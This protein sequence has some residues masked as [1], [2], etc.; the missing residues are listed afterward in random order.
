MIK[1]LSGVLFSFLAMTL[2]LAENPPGVESFTDTVVPTETVETPD[3]LEELLLPGGGVYLGEIFEHMPHGKGTISYPNGEQY[4]GHF[5]D[6]KKT[7]EGTLRLVSGDQLSAFWVDDRRMGDVSYRFVD[8]RVYQ[9]ELKAKKA[10]GYGVMHYPS[11]EIYTGYWAEGERQGMGLQE[12]SG[13]SFIGPFDNNLRHGK[14]YEAVTDGHRNAVW[15]ERNECSSS[16]L[17]RFA[18]FLSQL[19]LDKDEAPFEP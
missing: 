19:R 9:G 16:L 5:Q 11:G 17:V 13:R 12:E 2:A 7:G 10:H 14:G 18:Y 3:T 15:C 1:K 4:E 8:D 6:G